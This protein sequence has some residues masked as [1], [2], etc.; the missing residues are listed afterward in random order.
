MAG[1]YGSRR[2]L[3]LLLLAAQGC[4]PQIDGVPAEPGT[5]FLARRAIEDAR[6][7]R[8]FG[9]RPTGSDAAA[10]A[11]ELLAAELRRAGAEVEIEGWK[12]KHARMGLVG[13]G[14]NVV[15]LV[16]GRRPGATLVSARYDGSPDGPDAP[17]AY[18]AAVLIEIARA[19]RAGGKPRHDVLLLATE[20]SEG[21]LGQRAFVRSSRSQRVR[22]QLHLAVRGAGPALLLWASRGAGPAVDAYARWAAAPEGGSHLHRLLGPGDT[23][24]PVSSPWPAVVLGTMRPAAAAGSPQ[25]RVGGAR[26]TR[27]LGQQVL[28]LVRA[29]DRSSLED[30]RAPA[31]AFLDLPL[32]IVVPLGARTSSAMAW[33]TL[34]VALV[35]LLRA[36][37]SIGALLPAVPW[38]LIAFA[39]AIAAM[40]SASEIIRAVRGSGIGSGHLATMAFSGILW[41]LVWQR[42]GVLSPARRLAIG[43]S[44]PLPLLGLAVLVLAVGSIAARIAVPLAAHLFYGPLAFAAVGLAMSSAGA[45]RGQRLAGAVVAAS[46]AMSFWIAPAEHLVTLFGASESISSPALATAIAL[47]AL[48]LAP[49]VAAMAT[50]S[51]LRPGAGQ[52]TLVALITASLGVWTATEPTATRSSPRSVEVTAVTVYPNR[53]LFAVRGGAPVAGRPASLPW[54]ARGLGNSALAAPGG[55]T[56]PPH[57]QASLARSPGYALLDVRVRPL[58]R[59][60]AITLLLSPEVR[61][62]RAS[63][64]TVRWTERDP[65]TARYLNPPR[66]GFRYLARLEVPRGGGLGDFFAV[67]EGPANFEPLA[68]RV[69]RSEPTRVVLRAVGVSPLDSVYALPPPPPPL[70]PDMPAPEPAGPEPWWTIMARERYRR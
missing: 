54:F 36:R 53:S 17:G 37:R 42:I 15:A 27:E 64:P 62:R 18:G 46:G 6:A 1:T 69:D 33:L 48:P 52:L 23:G 67:D 21:Q 68:P 20:G 47:L 61:V 7:I 66:A 12:Q 10:R 2:L 19:L 58:R 3:A 30:R 8:G 43:L 49:Q 57:V 38:L 11:R 22:V 50:A 4:Q 25:D 35:V 55:I 5:R 29:L 40:A 24:L 28:D 13:E 51:V 63:L 31:P 39:G 32:H 59:A 44:S 65:W 9:P 41:L 26:P 34:V 45:T 56:I 70:P 60:D 14:K 16:R